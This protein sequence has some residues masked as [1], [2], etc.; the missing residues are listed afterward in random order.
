[1][2]RTDKD[3]GAFLSKS[4]GYP[5]ATQDFHSPLSSSYAANDFGAHSL[6]R[7]NSD[8]E[9]HNASSTT[10]ILSLLN[11][12]FGAGIL[13]FPF[14]FSQI[15]IIFG[16]IGCFASAI[17]NYYSLKI[18]SY[19]ALCMTDSSSRPET[20]EQSFYAAS[21]KYAP[22]LK[23]PID[24]CVLLQCVGVCAS[25]LLLLGDGICCLG[26]ELRD[27]FG[28]NLPFSDALLSKGCVLT[29][30]VCF[31]LLPLSIR[32]SFSSL[33]LISLFSML[34]VIYIVF[35]T[36]GYWIGCVWTLVQTD[37]KVPSFPSVNWASFSFKGLWSSLPIFMFGFSCQQ[38][39]FR[40]FNELHPALKN[41]KTVFGVCR[42]A[43]FSSCAIYTVVGIFGLLA[44]GSA[45]VAGS[46]FESYEKILAADSNSLLGAFLQMADPHGISLRIGRLFV[47][48]LVVTSFPMQLIPARES[49]WQ[50]L[51]DLF[52]NDQRFVKFVNFNTRSMLTLFGVGASSIMISGDDADAE[53][54]AT[55]E[56]CVDQESLLLEPASNGSILLFDAE[57]CN[58]FSGP[59]SVACTVF[60][61][62]FLTVL[63]C[64]IALLIAISSLNFE[65]VLAI[66]GSTGSSALA[67]VFGQWIFLRLSEDINVASDGYFLAKLLLKD[68]AEKRAAVNNHVL[69]QMHS[70]PQHTTGNELCTLLAKYRI[71]CKTMI[72][73]A[74]ILAVMTVYYV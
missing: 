36:V 6:L 63:L 66:I 4:N 12:V 16:T 46:I 43:I 26:R 3:E 64:A 29:V 41:S 60:F 13:A 2:W 33:R 30:A 53:P 5:T 74:V 7:Q 11:A 24:L 73:G 23:A 61:R 21:Q 15:G 62:C 51:V 14:A 9:V 58:T 57:R 72:V 38:N 48:M 67:F 10:A 34:S 55:D 70:E 8:T 42:S 65:K 52:R 49:L 32:E 59:S 45:S 37:S 17:C 54:L 1:M 44:V 25:Y 19:I 50:L 40:I 20:G 27:I 69:P 56:T 39:F 68:I 47:L 35:M 22:I 31:V 18:N 71:L 28:F